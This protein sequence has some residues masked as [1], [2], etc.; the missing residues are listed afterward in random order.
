MLKVHF[1]GTL[2]CSLGLGSLL[3]KAL[4]LNRHFMGG[5]HQYES[6]CP[7]ADGW[8]WEWGLGEY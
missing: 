5:L 4:H 6:G 1:L 3:S 7:H 2:D 8:E